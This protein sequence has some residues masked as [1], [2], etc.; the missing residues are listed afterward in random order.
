MRRGNALIY[1]KPPGE[2]DRI[3]IVHGS[4]VGALLTGNRLDNPESKEYVAKAARRRHF[5]R[6]ALN[7]DS[8]CVRESMPGNSGRF[9]RDAMANT[10][11]GHL[12]S[13]FP[14]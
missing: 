7:E 4:A 8:P 2:I 14:L 11:R 13:F 9:R 12:C 3:E 1:V 6:P 10:H 5:S